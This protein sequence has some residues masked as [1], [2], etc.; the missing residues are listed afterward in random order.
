M[1]FSQ[2]PAKCG[3]F[4][5]V[6]YVPQPLGSILGELA[7]NISTYHR[8][9]AHITLLPPR[10]LRMTLEGA[11]ERVRSAVRGFGSFEVE[12]TGVQQ[13]TE[14][15]VLYLGIGEGLERLNLL[16]EKLNA[17]GLEDKEEF[18]FLPHLT[19]SGPIGASDIERRRKHAES[20]WNSVTCSRKFIVDEAVF[21]CMSKTESTEWQRVWVESMDSIKAAHL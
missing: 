12:L 1:K 21:L 20:F 13:F 6:Y 5:V 7:G 18:E 19:L 4:A 8:P 3:H 2:Q 14:T 10:L 11:V 15:N 9:Q 16:H 17:G